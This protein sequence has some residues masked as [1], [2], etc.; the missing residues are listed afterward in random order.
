MTAD[1]AACEAAVRERMEAPVE[2]IETHAAVILLGG[3]A[4]FKLKKRVVFSFLDFRT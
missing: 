4:A 3:D 2:R 1:F